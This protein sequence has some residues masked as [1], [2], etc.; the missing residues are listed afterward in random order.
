MSIVLGSLTSSERMASRAPTKS[1]SP[2][3][4]SNKVVELPISGLVKWV[5]DLPGLP[6]G[7]KKKKD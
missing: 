6:V 1:V 2:S 7:E 3:L 4:L 5:T